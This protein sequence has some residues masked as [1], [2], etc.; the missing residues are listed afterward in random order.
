MRN[1]WTLPLILGILTALVLAILLWPTE[2]KPVT[3]MVAARDLGA[4][5]T[6]TAADLTALPMPPE[7]APADAVTNPDD[8]IGK[9]LAVVRFAGEPITSR[10]LGPAVTLQP[11][12]RGVAVKVSKD[13]GLAGLLRPGMKVGVVATLQDPEGRM[14]QNIF[15]KAALENLRVL[16]VPPDFQASAYMPV[17]RAAAEVQSGKLTAASASPA[18]RLAN[19]GVIVL[20]ASIEPQPILYTPISTTVEISYTMATD[21][22]VIEWEPPQAAPD[23]ANA[24][25]EWVSPAEFLAGLNAQGKALTL[26]LMPP[27]D[28][29]PW[30]TEGV[31]ASGIVTGTAAP[32]ALPVMDVTDE[33]KIGGGP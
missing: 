20:A 4:G 5:E 14:G 24:T 19:E 21:G 9:S 33:Q 27:N 10:H 15:A 13:R 12:E 22:T 1:K 11:D 31:L 16:Y 2:A 18:P 26:V 23:I 29:L 30:L 8:L 32:T 6:L 25:T 28:S 3:V 7:A 17:E